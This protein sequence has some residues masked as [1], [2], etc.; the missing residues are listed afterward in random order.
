MSNEA[1]LVRRLAWSVF[2]GLTVGGASIASARLQA[3]PSSNSTAS[4]APETFLRQLESSYNN[5]RTLRAEFTQTYTWGGR[6]RVESGTVYLVRGGAM[7]WEYRQPRE[8]LFVSD[9]KQLG[10]YIPEERQLTRSLVKNSEDVRV[11]FSLLL[12]R[13]NLRKIFSRVE[14]VEQAA[15]TLTH[16]RVLRGFPKRAQ[17]QDFSEVLFEVTPT[18]DVRRLVVYFVDHSTM[19]YVFDGME[20]NVSVSP[21]LFRFAPPPGTEVI[22]QRY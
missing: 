13:L 15:S 4:L 22:D 8:K 19:E 9:G 21:S 3:E 14:L 6:K 17:E 12:S 5:V 20:R 1:S 18:W 11:P 10:L 2:I 16:A 7:R